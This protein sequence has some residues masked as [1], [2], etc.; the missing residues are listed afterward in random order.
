MSKYFAS[1]CVK[2]IYLLSSIEEAQNC[3]LYNGLFMSSILTLFILLAGARYYFNQDV[4]YANQ[5][6]IQEYITSNKKNTLIF[7]MVLLGIVWVG[8]PVFSRY[9]YG[10]IWTGYTDSIKDLLAQG[11]TRQEAYAL[12]QS[13]DSSS[14]RGNGVIPITFMKKGGDNK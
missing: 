3:G 12:L 14:A 13:V 7:M 6:A 5:P 1:Y 4:K 8:I 2:P 10:N 11:F 9:G